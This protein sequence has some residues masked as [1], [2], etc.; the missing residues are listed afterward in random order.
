MVI[1]CFTCE[2]FEEYYVGV[3]AGRVGLC[4]GLWRVYMFYLSE[5][6]KH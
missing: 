1:G 5:A 6:D 4:N 2:G 3:E